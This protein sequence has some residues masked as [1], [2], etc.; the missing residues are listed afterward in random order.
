[1][2]RCRLLKDKNNGITS[3][4]HTLSFALS[5]SF[6]YTPAAGQSEDGWMIFILF[7]SAV[8][9]VVAAFTGNRTAL[10][11]L[12]SLGLCL[13]SDGMGWDRPPFVLMLI[14]VAVI[15][16]IFSRWPPK[17]S[18]IVIV[19]LFIPAWAGYLM[20][21]DTRYQI[22]FVVVVLQLALTFPLTR[23][24]KSMGGTAR[25]LHHRDDFDLRVTV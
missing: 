21:Q 11:L 6:A 5:E 8:C 2:R 25:K 12:A 4:T 13:L 19:S 7:F 9:A 20:P 16:F 10:P 22:G 18:D 3:H 14:D 1:M 15:A 24:L 17:A 23:F